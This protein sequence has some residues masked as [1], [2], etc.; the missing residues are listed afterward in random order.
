MPQLQ[1]L[2]GRMSAARAILGTLL[3]ALVVLGTA[4]VPQA[5]HAAPVSVSLSGQKFDRSSARSGES[6][7]LSFRWSIPEGSKGGDTFTVALPN[8][9]MPAST[10][11]F[12]LLSSSGDKV[13]EAQWSGKTATFTLTEFVAGKTNVNG[14]A[15]FN[16]QWDRS[17]VDM[18]TRHDYSL[19]FSGSGS[20]TLPLTLVP[21]GP[22]GTGQSTSKVGGWTTRDQGASS[23]KH[24]LMWAIYLDTGTGTRVPSPVV[25]TDTPG[26]SSSIDPNTVK[27]FANGVEMAKS[28]YTVE[29]L[30]TDGIRIELTGNYPGE[31]AVYRGENV[32]FTYQSDL[33]PGE[34]G[35]FT[36]NAVVSGL[37]A[38]P[39]HVSA[40]VVR[41]GAGGDG[42]GEVRSVVPVLPAVTQGVCSADGSV[43]VPTLALAETVGVTYEVAGDVAA[44]SSVVVTAVAADGYV[45]AAAEGW[46]LSADKRSATADVEFAE[47][48]CEQPVV[49][50][51]PGTPQTPPTPKTPGTPQTPPT[52]QAPQAPQPPQGALAQTG[53]ESVVPVLGFAIAATL[54][55]ALLILRNRRGLGQRSATTAE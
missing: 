39:Q 23:S 41:D 52:T 46:V 49:P 15:Y 32:Y 33:L 17:N 21:E 4:I 36:N 43:S 42:N 50:K 10:A 29:R 11:S 22:A 8:E 24:Q 1:A 37:Q 25:I 20:W 53:G 44:G 5:A 26:P 55:G 47:V 45:L 16:V 40:R 14:S 35:V 27:G 51:T 30:G 9:L 48:P 13:A 12:N 2:R 31:S 3:V 18:R 19:K 7:A 6:V 38:D 34:N 28:R 54:I